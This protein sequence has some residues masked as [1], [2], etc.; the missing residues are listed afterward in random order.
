MR[1][2]V[3]CFARLVEGQNALM[4]AKSPEMFAILL[5]TPNAIGMINTVALEDGKGKISAL[6]LDG[7]SVP[8]TTPDKHWTI[9]HRF[10]LLT[11]KHPSEATRRFLE[12]L[13]TPEGQA[14]IR[15]EKAFPVKLHL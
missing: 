10:H 8:L 9:N 7:R 2:G 11:G 4:V 6:K 3:A 12:F 15:K 13:N 5:S 1:E 14:A